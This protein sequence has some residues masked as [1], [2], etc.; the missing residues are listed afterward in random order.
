MNFDVFGSH[1]ESDEALGSELSDTERVSCPY[2]GE[3]S[4]LL[5]DLVGGSSQEYV[6]DCEVCCRPWSVRVRVDGEGYSSVS[7]TTLDN[8]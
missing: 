3:E 8:E 6:Q 5:V 7:V 2:C 1:E 4:E